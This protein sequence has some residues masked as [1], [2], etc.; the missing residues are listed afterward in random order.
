[1]ERAELALAG[2]R[3]VFL[4]AS[5]VA[6]GV[7]AFWTLVA[8][9]LLRTAGAATRLGFEARAR[10]LFRVA[11]IVAAAAALVWLVAQAAYMAEADSLSDAAAAVWP[12]LTRSS[13]AQGRSLPALS[14]LC[15][16]FTKRASSSTVSIARRLASSTPAIVAASSGVISPAAIA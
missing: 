11:M 15:S 12:V 7:A 2:V 13:L 1:M 5:L 4:A 10:R 8:P 3:G 16:S 14:M 6:F 9:P